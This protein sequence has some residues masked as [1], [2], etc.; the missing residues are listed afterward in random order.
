MPITIDLQRII[1]SLF[2]FITGL[3]G[4]LLCP[5]ND[6]YSFYQEPQ[7]VPHLYGIFFVISAKIRGKLSK[8]KNFIIE[9]AITLQIIDQS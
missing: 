5:V 1:H 4:Q 9:S 2:N 7:K 8:F 6:Q 3:I